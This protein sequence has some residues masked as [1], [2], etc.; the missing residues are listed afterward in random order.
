MVSATDDPWLLKPGDRL[1]TFSMTDISPAVSWN[2]EGAV[3]TIEVSAGAKRAVFPSG[4]NEWRK[5]VGCSVR[6]PAQE[7]KANREVIAIIAETLG[8]PR[9]SVRILAGETSS[10]KKILVEGTDPGVLVSRLTLAL[11]R[12]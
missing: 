12:E 6:A 2:E 5:A 8:T 9:R 3:L 11:Y 1:C 4:Y 10:L 7:G